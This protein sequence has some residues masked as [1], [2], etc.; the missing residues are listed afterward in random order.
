MN[1]ECGGKLGCSSQIEWLGFKCEAK[2]MKEAG[3]LKL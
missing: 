1:G 3:D 2:K